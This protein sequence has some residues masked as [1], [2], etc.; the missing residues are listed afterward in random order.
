VAAHR[1]VVG[2][3]VQASGSALLAQSVVVEMSGGAQ[4]ALL[5]VGVVESPVKASFISKGKTTVF[6]FSTA[7]CGRGTPTKSIFVISTLRLI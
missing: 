3:V 5:I 6:H 4:V 1:F 2:V 7:D